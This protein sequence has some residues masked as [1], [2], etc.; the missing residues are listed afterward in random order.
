MKILIVDD[1][2][3][4]RMRTSM[5]L[6]RVGYAVLSASSGVEALNMLLTMENL[7]DL[8]L[9]DLAM[10]E[11]DGWRFREI[12][13]NHSRFWNIPV[14]LVTEA[15]VSPEY[16]WTLGAVGQVLKPAEPRDLLKAVMASE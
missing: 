15:P 10:P 5:L 3:A 8:I 13:R 12:Q 2:T 1:D 16:L 6:R 9:L 14:L 11:M 4:F 7:P